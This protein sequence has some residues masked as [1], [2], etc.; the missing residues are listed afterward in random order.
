MSIIQFKRGVI[1]ANGNA[2][3]IGSLASL[4]KLH[5]LMKEDPK[6]FREFKDLKTEIKPKTEVK[7]HD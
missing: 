2:Y 5:H 3:E 4:V 6:K 1:M 7:D